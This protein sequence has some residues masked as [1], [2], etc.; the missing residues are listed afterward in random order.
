[1][2]TAALTTALD[3]FKPAIAAD[4]VRTVERLFANAVEALGP[5]LKGIYSSQRFAKVMSHGGI[6]CPFVKFNHETV[7]GRQIAHPATLR[8]EALE[9]AAAAY[10]DAVAVSWAAKI[11]A[12]MGELEG[13]TV[14]AL[15]GVAFTITGT[16]NG[17]AVAIEQQMVFKVSSKGTPFNQFPARL[18]LDGKAISE[19]AYSKAF[20]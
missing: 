14:H 8:V 10:A 12:K 2:T 15:N 3:A 16:R 7:A 13:A 19:A 17:H 18:R 4:Y 5:D 6:L 9:K 11:D 1:M 20:A